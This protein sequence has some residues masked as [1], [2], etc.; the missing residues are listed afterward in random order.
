MER[1]IAEAQVGHHPPT[2]PRAAQDDIAVP[3]VG[4]DSIA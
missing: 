4:G 2:F 3:V 1:D